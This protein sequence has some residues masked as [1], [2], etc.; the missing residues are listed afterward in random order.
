MEGSSQGL[1]RGEALGLAWEDVDVDLGQGLVRVHR[2]RIMLGW[3]TVIQ[4]TKTDAGQRTLALTPGAVTA[5]RRTSALQAQERLQAGPAYQETG[6][7][8]VDALG[9]PVTPRWYGDRF[10]ALTRRAGVPVTRLHDARHA[11]GSHLLDQGVPLTLVSEALGMP[12]RTPPR[13]STST[14]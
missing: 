5:L 3:E 4:G 12:A 7:V 14:R 9:A 6:L 2:N 1:R 8:V 11:Y 13:R 10:K